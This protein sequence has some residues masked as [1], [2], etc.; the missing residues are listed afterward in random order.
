MIMPI[1]EELIEGMYGSTF[2]SVFD[3]FAGY[4][5]VRIKEECIPLTAVSTPFGLYEWIVLPFGPTNGPPVFQGYTL[6]TFADFFDFLK[7]FM[8]DICVHTA[9]WAE[10]LIAQS[11]ILEENPLAL[12]AM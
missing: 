12:L 7:V 8:D 3:M 6:R 9:T 4:F 10:H 2:F 5:Q 11:A 1:I